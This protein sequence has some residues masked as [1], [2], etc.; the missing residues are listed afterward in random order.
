MALL[1]KLQHIVAH[2]WPMLKIQKAFVGTTTLEFLALYT[3]DQSYYEGNISGDYNFF[4]IYYTSAPL[5]V[6][7]F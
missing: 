4:D 1:K 5:C 2:S 6:E 3:G 7:T